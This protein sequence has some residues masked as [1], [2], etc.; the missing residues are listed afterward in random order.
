MN[1]GK[2]FFIILFS[3][4]LAFA[5]SGTSV[6]AAEEAVA[7]E[8]TKV[9]EDYNKKQ[10]YESR[11]LVCKKEAQLGTRVK[12]KVCRTRAAMDKAERDAKEIIDNKTRVLTEKTS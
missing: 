1:T 11:K 5:G 3:L 6:L 7:D 12:R 9:A 4:T 8:G 2:R 10:K